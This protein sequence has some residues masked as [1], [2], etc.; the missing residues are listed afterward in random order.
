MLSWIYELNLEPVDF[1]LD[2]KLVIDDFHLNNYD[3]AE[4]GEIILYCRR[5]TI[6]F[7]LTLM[8][9]LLQMRLFI[10]YGFG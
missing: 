8:L 4:F 5:Y 1:E 6:L 3:V 9:N 2:T 7:I 10:V